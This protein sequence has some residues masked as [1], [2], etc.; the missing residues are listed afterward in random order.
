MWYAIFNLN[1][2]LVAPTI[3]LGSAIGLLKYS[4][5]LRRTGILSGF[6]I[7]LQCVAISAL[8][9]LVRLLISALHH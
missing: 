2:P 4:I 9:D 7:A 8:A 1:M 3:T 5:S 6:Q